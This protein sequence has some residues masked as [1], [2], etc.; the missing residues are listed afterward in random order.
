MF[1]V[2]K[3]DFSEKDSGKF[4]WKSVLNLRSYMNIVFTL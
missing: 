4:S 2:L 3:H 1:I